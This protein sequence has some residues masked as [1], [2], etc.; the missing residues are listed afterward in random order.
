MKKQPRHDH[1]LALRSETVRN[2]NRI[3]LAAAVGGAITQQA[4]CSVCPSVHQVCLT[5]PVLD[6]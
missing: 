1:K 2:L 4:T 6:A 3:E 5:T